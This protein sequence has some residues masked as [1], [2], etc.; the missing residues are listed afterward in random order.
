MNETFPKTLIE[1]IKYFGNPDT[2]L[3]CM[4]A[5]RWPEGIVCPRCEA[6]EYSFVKTRRIWI[7]KGCKKHFSVKIGTIMED[8]PIGL[9]KWLSAIW[10]IVNAKNGISSYEIHRSLG[11]TQKS[12]WFMLHRIRVAMQAGTF[13]KLSGEVE[14]DET[15]IGGKARNMHP[16]RR[17]RAQMTA[18]PVG[19]VAVMGLLERHGEVRTMVVPSLRHNSLHGEV[20]RH[21]ERNSVVYSDSFRSYNSLHQDFIHQVI[22]HAEQYVN[23]HIHTNGIENFW[24]LLKRTLGGT[25]ISVEPF[26]LFRYL[27][28]QAFRFNN[29]KGNDSDRFLKAARNVTGKRLTLKD[30]TGKG[31]RGYETSH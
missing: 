2:A 14:V 9:D 7:C 31:P 19:K 21:V 12:A 16:G 24:S 28:E 13:Q 17:A 29:R 11:I 6:T 25:Y 1:A 22:N 26:H 30:L 20:K 10:L 27:D 15:F 18:G 5:I 4:V 8:S 3:G 23:G